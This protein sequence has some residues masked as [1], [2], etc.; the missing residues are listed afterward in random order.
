MR[1]LGGVERLSNSFP[2]LETD[3]SA[4]LKPGFKTNA[5]VGMENEVK[6]VFCMMFLL[7]EAM[8]YFA[9]LVGHFC[10]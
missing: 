10:C 7:H 4:I 9:N 3:T 6:M 2:C 8:Y 1:H 5:E